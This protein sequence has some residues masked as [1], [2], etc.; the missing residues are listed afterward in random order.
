LTSRTLNFV[1]LWVT[2]SQKNLFTLFSSAKSPHVK[3]YYIY[4]INNQS[5][6][7][8]SKSRFGFKGNLPLL[9]E[10]GSYSTINCV[11]VVPVKKPKIERIGNVFEDFAHYW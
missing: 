5:Q 7:P 10:L 4:F 1:S 2:Y 6:R 11:V 9:F 8:L 3:Y